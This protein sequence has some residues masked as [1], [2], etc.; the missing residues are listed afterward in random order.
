[1]S[2]FDDMMNGLGIKPLKKDEKKKKNNEKNPM[3][4][5]VDYSLDGKKVNSK[6]KN[7]QNVIKEEDTCFEEKKKTSKKNRGFEE[8]SFEEAL[9]MY[10]SVARVKDD[11]LIDHSKLDAHIFKD[12]FSKVD[13]DD[14]MHS[15]DLHN[16]TLDE[17]ESLVKAKVVWCYRE[18]LDY[19]L[20]IT[21]KGNHSDNGP[22]LKL[23]IKNLLFTMSGLIEMF[24]YAPKSLGGEGAYVVRLKF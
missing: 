21:G 12:R 19:L 11:E 24:E 2:D 13:V 10:S 1:M 8:K 20:V 5:F 15:I 14:I 17:A 7:S 9:K 16:Y 23:G 6:N 22:V 4:E 18:K 3:D